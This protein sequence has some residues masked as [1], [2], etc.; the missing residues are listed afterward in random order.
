MRY[1]RT[2]KGHQDGGWETKEEKEGEAQAGLSPRP[3]S[4]SWRWPLAPP[5]SCEWQLRA[6]LSEHLG[7]K[8][9]GPAPGSWGLPPSAML[10]TLPPSRPTDSPASL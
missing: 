7:G 6:Q 10:A 4:A 1:I 8:G 5:L 3:S 9:L 2:R